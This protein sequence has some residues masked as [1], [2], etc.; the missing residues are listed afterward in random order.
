MDLVITIWNQSFLIWYGIFK[1]L[2]QQ[3]YSSWKR[4]KGGVIFG[5]LRLAIVITVT[6]GMTER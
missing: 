4:Q 2:I 1:E 6:I 3:G 5:W